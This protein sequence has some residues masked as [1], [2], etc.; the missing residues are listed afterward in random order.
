MNAVFEALGD[1]AFGL[2]A[3]EDLMRKKLSVCLLLCWSALSALRCLN[4][5]GRLLMLQGLPALIVIPAALWFRAKKAAG[6]GDVWVLAVL[7]FFWD[8]ILFTNAVLLGVWH[9]GMCASIVTAFYGEGK[10]LPL[11][12]FLLLGWMSGKLL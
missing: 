7:S 12:P 4:T 5:D 1:A 3:L 8:P 9:L 10:S 2:L 11:V 6:W